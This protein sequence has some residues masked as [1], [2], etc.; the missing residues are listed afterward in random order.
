[1]VALLSKATVNSKLQKLHI[2]AIEKGSLKVF[3]LKRLMTIS[4]S[5]VLDGNVPELWFN[6]ICA[7]EARIV[8]QTPL[9]IAGMDGRLD[10]ILLRT[11]CKPNCDLLL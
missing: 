1:M 8:S 2:C 9:I 7:G 11:V 5:S 4:R 10:A 6:G 3:N